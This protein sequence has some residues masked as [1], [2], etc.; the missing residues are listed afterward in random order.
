MP[1]A[2]PLTAVN[3]IFYFYFC[4]PEIVIFSCNFSVFSIQESDIGNNHG[5]ILL[6]RVWDR[7]FLLERK[8]VSEERKK[9]FKR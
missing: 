4:D 9:L 2:S 8:A 3:Y 1:R 7:R 6:A 5:D